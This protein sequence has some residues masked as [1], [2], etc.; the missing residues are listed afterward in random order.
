[1]HNPAEFS[2]RR[3]RV[4]VL[5]TILLILTGV[6]SYIRLPRQENP[7]FRDRHLSV[8]TYLP[9]AE[10]EK[11]ELLISKVLEDHI[12][13][14]D[15]IDSI[16][17][18]SNQGR[19]FI[20]VQLKE[21]APLE[22]RMQEIRD[23][24]EEARSQFPPGTSEP[25]VD[26]D[27]IFTNTMILTLSGE[28]AAPITLRKQAKMIKRRLENLPDMRKVE[29][30][31]EPE[32]E[33]SVDVDLRTLSQK[34]ITLTQVVDA[35]QA[36]NVLLPSGELEVGALKSAIQTSGAYA[37]VTEIGATYLGA[38]ENGLPTRLADVATITR[39]LK[40]PDVLV[41]TNGRRAV[42]IAIEMLPKRSAI[43]LGAHVRELITEHASTLPEGMTLHIAAD[44]PTY[45]K[46]RLDRLL[47]SLRVGLVLVVGLVI[48]GMGWRSGLIVS[49]SIPLSLTIAMGGL[50]L[51]GIALH[52][53]SIA[54]LVIAIGL[55]V[56]EAIVVTD[57]IQR[58][59]DLGASPRE[60]SIKG[61]GEIHMAVLAGAFTTI[62]AFIPLG[63]MSGDIGDFIRSIPI[64]VSIMLL[65]SVTVAHYFTPLFAAGMHW[66]AE[67]SHS[68]K[69]VERHRVEPHYRAALRFVTTH[70]W[71]ALLAFGLFFLTSVWVTKTQLLPP[72]FFPAADRH[73]LLIRAELPTGSPVEETDAVMR[74]IEARLAEH[75]DVADYTA[76][77]GAG[78]PK[79]YYNEFTEGRNEGAGMFI[80]NT[81][82]SLP[83]DR[84]A[85]LAAS[86]E[87]GLQ[88]SIVGAHIRVSELQQG[89]GGGRDVY[90]YI[91]GDNLEMLR[92][93]S[94]QVR[95][96]IKQVE[97]IENAGEQ[98]GFDPLTL[99]VQVDDAKANLLGITHAEVATTLRTAVDGVP[100]TTFRE[101]DEEID[102]VV[103]L[104]ARQRE[105]IADLE[106]LQVYSPRTGGTVPLSQIGTL[107]PT[108]TTRFI[109]RWKRQREG[110]VWADV[111]GRRVVAATEEIKRAVAEH[112]PIPRGYTISYEGEQK[113]VMDSFLSLAQ[114]ALWAIFLIYI[115]LVVQFNSLAQPLLIILAIPM[116][117]TGATWGLA[118]T[119]NALGFMA[120]VGLIALTGIVVNDSIV[121]LDYINRLRASGY[122]LEDAVV[123]GATTRLR[124]V[125]LTSV[126]T[127]GGLLPLSLR[128]GTFW[129]PFGYAMIFGLAASTVLTLFVQP[130]AY[131]TLE[132]V[133][134]RRPPRREAAVPAG[135]V[136]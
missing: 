27:T 113:Q 1:M 134:A 33:I 75:P 32:E 44:E 57:N 17:S 68:P 123:T 65:A 48:L 121:L 125:V 98:F 64:A 118:L 34:G 128:G 105:T 112:V 117:L 70:T 126:T 20:L 87:R 10:P 88:E 135:M 60:A 51:A 45:V 8:M 47:T 36:R 69:R 38:G 108:W 5:A 80:V 35:L 104:A 99:D 101:E 25:D 19:S 96:T 119:G 6:L 132:R 59:R 86:L 22:D 2:L 11:V 9:G 55:V 30:L 124:P 136:D 3:P 79:F 43:R 12:A 18:E 13:Q 122:T 29:L 74:Q 109:N 77:V 71:L 53:I 95:D 28:G 46:D 23:K 49:V 16:M 84:T 97:G 67:R 63:M 90:I 115:I 58:H 76:F 130:A 127:I 66:L 26:L 110:V 82:R 39:R 41:R 15:D 131:L 62:A 106:M 31:G 73:Q 72:I 56:D 21:S 37:S 120:F 78:A 91:Q 24:V 129:E 111:K 81:Q 133:R 100:A 4:V 102:I 14:V 89:Y 92:A 94:V 93:L 103:R 61:L 52:Q 7:T 83:F 54:A 40:E 114:A 85:E 42:S 116:A 107:V 50:S